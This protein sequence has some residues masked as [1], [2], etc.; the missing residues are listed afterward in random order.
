MGS[1]E[2][3]QELRQAA[4]DLKNHLISEFSP[5]LSSLDGKLWCVLT[6]GGGGLEGFV[7]LKNAR[8]VL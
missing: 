8:N 2:P 1:K 4:G 6:G 7:R 3:C 5:H